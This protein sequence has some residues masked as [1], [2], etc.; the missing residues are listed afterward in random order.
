MSVYVDGFVT[1]VPASNKDAYRATAA[2]SWRIFADYGALRSVECWEDDVPDGKITD[3]RKAVKTKDDEV[4]VFSWIVW[5]SK[6]TRDECYRKL[7]E[8]PRM[9]NLEMPFDGSRMIWGGF[10]PLFDSGEG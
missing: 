2:Q 9:K 1:A 7:A 5:P 8:D 10:V 3:F 6:E 4:V